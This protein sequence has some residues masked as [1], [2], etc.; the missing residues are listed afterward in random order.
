MPMAACSKVASRRWPGPPSGTAYSAV[1]PGTAEDGA[2]IVDSDADERGPMRISG[3][4][5]TATSPI[6]QSSA[7]Q[8]CNVASPTDMEQKEFGRARQSSSQLV[9]L[10][11]PRD[12]PGGDADDTERYQATE[13]YRPN[14]A[15]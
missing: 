13:N 15:K 4:N 6:A 14:G 2:R 7:S 9:K 5:W 10:S 1:H 3:L 11:K 12:L 8:T